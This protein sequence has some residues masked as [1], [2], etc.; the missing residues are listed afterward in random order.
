MHLF[1]VSSYEIT[2]ALPKEVL[3]V[4]PTEEELNMYITTTEDEENEDL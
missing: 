2:K 4:L 1:G 3:E